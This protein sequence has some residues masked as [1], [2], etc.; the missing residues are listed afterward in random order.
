V[1]FT[2]LAA[3]FP[4]REAAEDAQQW[5]VRYAVKVPL[6]LRRHDCDKPEHQAEPW[7]LL[8]VVRIGG[9]DG[10]VVA[11]VGVNGGGGRE[12]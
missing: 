5:A 9:E 10:P 12:S 1:T 7:L 8:S 6:E 11:S 4:T 3:R 2:R